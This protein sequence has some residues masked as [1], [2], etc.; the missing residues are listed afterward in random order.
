MEQ[1]NAILRI[2]RHVRNCFPQEQ[3]AKYR[4]VGFVES[5]RLK[6]CYGILLWPN[7]AP[8][9][10]NRVQYM[11]MKRTRTLAV[12][13][14]GV[15]AEYDGWQGVTSLGKP[16]QD[17]VEV[18]SILR[19][20]GWR[21]IVHTTRGACE[22]EHYLQAHEIPYDEINRNSQ[23]ANTGPKPVAT[24]YWDD[25]A[26][27]YSGNALADLTLIRDFKTWNGRK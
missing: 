6:Y 12:D 19:K 24:I 15:V 14:D 22:V 18:L 10:R 27:R 13:F 23:Y 2:N 8:D 5:E 16:R 7:A 26:L 21:I 4:R 1:E 3:L 20:E 25:R 9:T 17:V 11:E